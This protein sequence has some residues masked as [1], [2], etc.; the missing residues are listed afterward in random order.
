VAARRPHSG[1]VFDLDGAF[2]VNAVGA[3]SGVRRQFS[4]QYFLNGADH[5]SGGSS[6]RLLRQVAAYL[7]LFFLA[8]LLMVARVGQAQSIEPRSYSNAPIG[9]N[10]LIVGTGFSH[11]G[12]AF[13]PALPLKNPS[14]EVST[15]IAAYS[16]VLD[17]WGNSGSFAVLAPYAWLSG[18]ADF[19]GQ[20]VERETSGLA[21][22]G[23]RFSA[24]LFGAPALSL[25]D[26]A[27]YQQDLVVGASV[28]VWAP[29][30]RY[31]ATRMVNIGTNR[32]SIRPEVGVSKAFGAWV[33]DLAVACT[34]YTDNTDFY[35]GKTRSQD[36]L[37]SAQGNLIYTF[38]NRVWVSLGGTFYGGGRSAI[39]DVAGND[40]QQNWRVGSVVSV[41]LNRYQSVKLMAGSGVSA[42]TGNN[43]DNVGLEW[44]Y[45]WGGGL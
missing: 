24:N 31:D 32:W 45:R 17:L 19:N 25:Q 44:Q 26:F 18:S 29:T 23:F 4:T 16:R 11:G 43:F 37:F 36:P 33:A 10:F 30:G 38:Q 2:V 3:C 42:R 22:M 39:D 13:D 40:L 41:P 1:R 8:V 21:D 35:G 12:L 14:L 15:A 20:R 28:V 9:M 6:G 34:F 5:D 7:R 27:S